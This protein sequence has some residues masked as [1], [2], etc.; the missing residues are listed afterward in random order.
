[1]ATTALQANT[2]PRAVEPLIQVVSNRHENWSVRGEAAIALGATGDSRGLGPLLDV[3]KEGDKELG[4]GARMGL[5]QLGGPAVE[6][7]IAL[8]ADSDWRVRRLAAWALR[9]L[10]DGRSVTALTAA[11]ADPD[12]E[13]QAA[14]VSAFESLRDPSAVEP[15]IAVLQNGQPWARYCAAEAL[16][17][18]GDPRALPSLER[19]R[20]HDQGVALTNSRVAEAA[21]RAIQ[22]IHA[23][24][25]RKRRPKS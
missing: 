6:P 4:Y 23:Q 15:L 1:M 9:D 13:V 12:P 2:D 14:A 22:V 5:R 3:L 10:G 17:A 24:Q 20:D 16:G 8:L 21:E 18:I 11:L 7:L 25:S 19:A